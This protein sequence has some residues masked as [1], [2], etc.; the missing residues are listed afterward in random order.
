LEMG[1]RVEY[2]S[3]R[4]VG[5]FARIK[6]LD[7][8]PG[9][10]WAFAGITI[11]AE[12][13][14]SF[15]HREAALVSG[16]TLTLP[17][18]GQVP[19]YEKPVEDLF[20]QDVEIWISTEGPKT[21]FKKVGAATLRKE[22][23]PHDVPFPAPV[24]AR[25]VKIVI[26]SDYGSPLG[27]AIAEIAVREGKAPGYV[28]LLERH[29]ALASLLSTGVLPAAGAAATASANADAANDAEPCAL[30]GRPGVRPAVPESKVVLV[31]SRESKTRYAPFNYQ[32]N[33]PKSPEVRYFPND[34][35]DGRVDSS[36]F[37]RAEFWA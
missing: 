21:G 16:V 17:P 3:S 10:Y 9:T 32:V 25:F 18:R 26:T 37:Q 6:M 15:F 30:P 2:W 22:S 7:G 33:F 34:P 11:P 31:V 29:P 5:D 4:D 24:E 36:I 27:P 23:G 12:G 1:G 8:N 19:T 35:G 20:A 14:V 28:P 13:T